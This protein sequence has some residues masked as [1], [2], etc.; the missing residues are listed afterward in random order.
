MGFRLRLPSRTQISRWTVYAL[1]AGLFISTPI[2]VVTS[3]PVAQAASTYF[4]NQYDAVN[5]GGGG[6][7]DSYRGANCPANWVVVGFSI[8]GTSGVGILC[9][10]LSADG[11]MANTPHTTVLDQIAQFFI[12]LSGLVYHQCKL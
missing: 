3:A 6:G 11:T 4:T 9:R 5:Y 12:L 8:A 1:F 7:G 10:A 2:A